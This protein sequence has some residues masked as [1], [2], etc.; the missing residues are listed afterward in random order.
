M[1]IFTRRLKESFKI[2]D[3]VTVTVVEIKGG[4]VRIGV[5]APRNISVHREEVYERIARRC[6]RPGSGESDAIA[7]ASL[8]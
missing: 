1:L 5:T 6:E 7:D 3:H 2:G 8:A 4:Q